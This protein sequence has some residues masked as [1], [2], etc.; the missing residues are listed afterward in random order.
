MKLLRALGIKLLL[1]DLDGTLGDC[2]RAAYEISPE[3]GKFIL[4]VK[5]TLPFFKKN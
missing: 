4:N 1:T 5:I 3:V 2:K